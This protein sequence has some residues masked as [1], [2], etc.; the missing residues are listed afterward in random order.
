MGE[1]DLS[2]IL[3]NISLLFFTNLNS[4][5]KHPSPTTFMR[6]FAPL[7]LYL[8]N[9][10]TSKFRNL[11]SIITPIIQHNALLP[12][13]SQ[14][15]YTLSSP[16]TPCTFI[17]APKYISSRILLSPRYFSPKQ[18]PHLNPTPLFNHLLFF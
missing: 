8:F 6:F 14:S 9:K 2:N 3:W 17:V 4:K 5:V 13:S 1:G 12:Y 15:L 11:F 18:F 10:I 16:T 7:L